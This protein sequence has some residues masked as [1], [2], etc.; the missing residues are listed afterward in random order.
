MA[1]KLG[2]FQIGVSGSSSNT[3]NELYANNRQQC[4]LIINILKLKYEGGAWQKMPLS[5]AEVNS[6]TVLPYSSALFPDQAPGWACDNSANGYTVGL[7]S[8][9]AAVADAP[10]GVTQTVDEAASRTN[11]APEVF[12]R[13]MRASTTQRQD[14]MACVTLDGNQ[15]YSTHYD[16]GGDEK[17]ESFVGIQ[18]QN[19]YTLRVSDL[20]SSRQDA[21]SNEFEKGKWVDVDTYYWTLPSGLW[22][23]SESYSGAGYTTSK[24]QYAYDNRKDNRVRLGMA[25]KLGVTSLTLNE[26]YSAAPSG[27]S[28]VPLINA[29]TAMR[30]A[31]YSQDGVG[32]SSY[33]NRL[34]WNIIDNFG[35]ESRFVLIANSGDSGNTLTLLDA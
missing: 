7:R 27:S 30:G 35:C 29:N 6:L 9:R 32:G 13:Y 18:P 28:Q 19:P 31:R 33:D 5:T 14:F 21:Y 20:A 2:V 8:P 34:Y 24:L 16:N 26:I 12:Y 22:I 3:T 1:T 17:Y 15:R 25:I 4:K 11:D 23:S 10:S